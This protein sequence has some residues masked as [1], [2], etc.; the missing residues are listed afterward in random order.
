MF[1][2]AVRNKLRLRMVLMGPSGSG[3]TYTALKILSYLSPDKPVFAI[4]TENDSTLRYAPND[5]GKFDIEKGIFDFQQGSLSEYSPQKYIA[6]IHGAEAA[7][8]GGISIDSLSHAW[9]GSGGLL[10]QKNK[11]DSAGG[12]SYT[13][14]AKI[15]P[16]QNEL[17]GAITGSPTHII[18][19]LRTKQDIVLE[20]NDRGRSVPRRVGLAAVQRDDI[21][22]EFDIV[23]MMDMDNNLTILKSR[24][25]DLPNGTII[26]KPGVAF[27]ATLNAFLNTGVKLPL[28][29]T[30]FIDAM[31]ALGYTNDK[32]ATFVQARDNIQGADRWDQLLDIARGEV[33]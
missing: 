16:Q 1:K 25:A 13:N 26:E 5:D 18:A 32:M 7:G 19:C 8:A 21:E 11:L 27:A 6:L 4:D 12:N 9:A 23:G 24:S 29:K 20:I 33:K 31:K 15:T 28:T 10:D 3:K 14:W 17:I 2:P 30:Q 22:Y